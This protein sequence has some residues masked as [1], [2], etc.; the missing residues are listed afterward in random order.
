MVLLDDPSGV[1]HDLVH[2]LHHAVRGQATVLYTQIHAAAAAVHPD[3][4]LVS[5]GKLG[6]Q[7]VAGVG[8]EDVVVVKAGG[9]AV[10]HQLAHTR[11]GGEADHFAVQ[12]L[13]DLVQSFQPVKQLHILHL[14]QIAG[15]DLIQMVVRIHKAGVAQHV[16]AVNDPV[17]CGVQAGADLLNKAV[18]AQHIHVVQHAVI[19]VTGDELGNV[20]DKQG[21][22]GLSSFNS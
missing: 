9:A 20:L 17:G 5:G 6:A 3:A 2:G 14:G 1:L 8:G 10:L 7:Q 11:E 4:Q 19:V 15:E 16:A 21:R 22:H 12:I 13:P 18:L